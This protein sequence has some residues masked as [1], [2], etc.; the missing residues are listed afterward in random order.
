[1]TVSPAVM[2][3]GE[4]EM[5][6]NVG[7]VVSEAAKASSVWNAPRETVGK[8]PKTSMRDKNALKRL[9][10]KYYVLFHSATFPKPCWTIPFS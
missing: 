7:A 9:G 6:S 8:S 5:D 10:G 4:E 2:V 3:F 1:M